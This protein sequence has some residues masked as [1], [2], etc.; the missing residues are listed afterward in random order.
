MLLL[1]NYVQQELITANEGQLADI[2]DTVVSSVLD[3]VKTQFQSHS[4]AVKGAGNQTGSS[5]LDQNTLKTV[6]KNVV[7]EEDR[8]KNF[9]IFGLP[10]DAKEQINSKV[11]EV[12]E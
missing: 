1:S 7:E 5:L 3:T 11:N 9:L 8:S 4:D 6:V 12:L 10:E 2:R